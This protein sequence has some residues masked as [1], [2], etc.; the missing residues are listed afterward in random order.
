[1]LSKNI[2]NSVKSTSE[3]TNK[4]FKKKK[5]TPLSKLY[6][7]TSFRDSQKKNTSDP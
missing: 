4:I 6:G 7:A 2:Q 1:M 5:E 3:T